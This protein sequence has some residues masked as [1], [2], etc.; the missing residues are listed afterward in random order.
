MAYLIDGNNFLG[1][2]SPLEIRD[3]RSRYVLVLKLLSFQGQKKNRIFLVFDGP[4]DENLEVLVRE[5]K[6]F[7]VIYPPRGQ[8]A[9]AVI[10]EIL[11]RQADLRRFFVVTSDRE[12]SAFARGRG[13][14][15]LKPK[16]FNQELRNALKE[17]RKDRELAKDDKS[18]TSLEVRLWDD[19]FRE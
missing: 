14:S 13:A 18:L 16:A 9:D 12:L 15:V 19:V 4:P 1:H 6:K 5:R 10:Q 7:F 3:S 17:R 2:I 8:K 11:E